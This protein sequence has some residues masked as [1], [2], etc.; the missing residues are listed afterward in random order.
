MITADVMSGRTIPAMLSEIEVLAR[1]R[2][3]RLVLGHHGQCSFPH[4]MPPKKTSGLPMTVPQSNVLAGKAENAG[5]SKARDGFP[6]T[7]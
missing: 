7:K 5:N 6:L 4:P 3:V 2:E 1:H